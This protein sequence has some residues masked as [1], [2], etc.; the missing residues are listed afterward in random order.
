MMLLDELGEVDG[1]DHLLGGSLLSSP[2]MT[3]TSGTIADLLLG[4]ACNVARVPIGTRALLEAWEAGWRAHTRAQR[5]LEG[6]AGAGGGGS[7]AP[8]AWAGQGAKEPV[9]GS[10]PADRRGRVRARERE[11]F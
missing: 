5:V 9:R 10:V 8:V 4:R 3:C 1:G 11:N 6:R 2:T 7:G